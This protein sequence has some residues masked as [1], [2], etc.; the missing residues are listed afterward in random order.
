MIIYLIGYMGCGK[1]TAG[2]RLANKLGYQFID[3][4]FLIE[5]D[6]KRTISE[7]FS[8]DG[9][10]AFRVIE[11]ET[12]HKTFQLNSCV[13]A[14]GGGAP[15][16]YDNM[17]QMNAHG[18]TLYIKLTPKALASRLKSGKDERPIIAGKTDEELLDFIAE[19]LNYREQFYLQAQ[20]TINGIGL[21]AQNMIKMLGI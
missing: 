14:T 2:K 3:L 9:Q 17:H 18:K 20:Y 15:C 19:A 11:R 4:D 12:L 10:D 8:S 7:I 13:I 16:F 6:Q 21:N 1:T 5:N